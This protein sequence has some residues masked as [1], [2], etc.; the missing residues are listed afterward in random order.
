MNLTNSQAETAVAE[1]LEG[2]RA[3]K[4]AEYLV[5]YGSGLLTKAELVLRIEL[6]IDHAYDDYLE[7]LSERE[8][9][10]GREEGSVA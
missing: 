9:M 1:I 6:L 3:K 8:G 2:R 4:L 7:S 5:Q 10:T